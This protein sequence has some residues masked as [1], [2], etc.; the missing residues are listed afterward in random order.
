[1]NKLLLLG[2]LVV[3]GMGCEEKP[4]E[5]PMYTLF[6]GTYTNG[7]SE[8]IYSYQFD[9]DSGTLSNKSLEAKLPNPSFLAIS[10]D[11]QHLYAV[12][13]TADFDSLGGG[14]SA[15]KLKEGVLELQNSKGTG[16]ANPCHVSLSGD[17]FLSVANYS[18]GNVALFH[19]NDDGS[20][21][22]NP[23]IIDHKV[24]DTTKT[25]H[26]HM[27]KFTKDGLFATDLGLDA[28]KRYV[29]Q[30]NQWVPAHQASIDFPKGAGP[31]HFVFSEN[32][33][34]LYVINELNST[35]TVLQRDDEGS[36]NPI[37]TENTLP[38]NYEGKNACADIH[39]SPDGQFLYGTNRG[40]NTIVIFTV[41]PSSGTLNLVGRESVQGNWPRN[42]SLDPTGNF[43]L[44][45]NQ[46]SNNIVVFKRDKE[47][48]SL[49]YLNEIK[50][51]SPVCL[52]FLD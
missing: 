22:D 6:I 42:F 27:T 39:L 46:L 32:E 24:L 45:A 25:A 47:T 51:P 8:G 1:M 36:Y 43:L 15:F 4:Q 10:K 20:L 49:T 11:K 18:G 31:R 40:E 35:L 29:K 28:L 12:Q 17:G 21:G 37:Q 26:A 3:L 23:Q 41:D 52:T 38:S 30:S 16:G 5:K 50:M 44:V 34:F 48:G 7:D 33:A 19:L 2:L 14:V 9:A 13:E